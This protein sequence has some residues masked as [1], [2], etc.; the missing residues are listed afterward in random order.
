LRTYADTSFLV[1][2][3]LTQSDSTTALAFL[4]DFRDPLPFTP[5][6]RHELRNAIRLA[7]FRQEI[8]MARRKAAFD[9]IESDLDDGILAHVPAPWTNAFREAEQLG[10]AH[11]EAM[12][13]RGIDLLH[14]GVALALGAKVFLTFDT[15]QADLA[16]VAGL[17]VKP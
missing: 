1:R 4:R 2:I 14:T 17:K 7:V 11:T 13:V 9:D 16:K 10:S 5:L 12:G 6:H 15:R 3:Y 8:D